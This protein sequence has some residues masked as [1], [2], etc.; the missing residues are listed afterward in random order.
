VRKEK[1][2]G[3]VLSKVVIASAFVLA[4]VLVGARSASA[5]LITLWDYDIHSSV[6]AFAP[7]W[8]IPGGPNPFLANEPT[9]LSWGVSTGFGPSELF[10]TDAAPS[11]SF[12]ATNGAAVSGPT[13]TAINRPITDP[14]N[15]SLTEA[16]LRVRSLF[17]PNQPPGH[18][19]LVPLLQDFLITFKE[20][21]L[22]EALVLFNPA[23]LNQAVTFDGITYGL[24]L[25]FTG[26]QTL[27]STLCGQA[28]AGAGCQGLLVPTNEAGSLTAAFSITG[29]APPALSQVPEP[30]TILLLASGLAGL[31]VYSWKKTLLNPYSQQTGRN[32]PCR[33]V[34]R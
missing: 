14:T 18:T 30:S 28:G 4:V 15:Q 29:E 3:K 10:V 26:L 20:T 6:S 34:P 31:F 13:L 32:R 9:H 17:N 2:V 19:L 24:H 12:V 11:G 33:R 8:A 27:S 1:G 5:D 16:S 25:S 23:D 21:S 22:K 7:S